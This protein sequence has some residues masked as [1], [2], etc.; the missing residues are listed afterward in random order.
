MTD[1]RAALPPLPLFLGLL[2]TGPTT[3]L[4]TPALF[5]R[6]LDTGQ[7]LFELICGELRASATPLT[8]EEQQV[9]QLPA[10]QPLVQR[11]KEAAQL[12]RYARY[13][14]GWTAPYQIIDCPLDQAA[15]AAHLVLY[16]YQDDGQGYVIFGQTPEAAWARFLQ[17]VSSVFDGVA[18][19][20]RHYWALLEQGRLEEAA[21]MLPTFGI[22]HVERRSVPRNPQISR[23][24]QQ[25]E[26]LLKQR[27]A[28]HLT[29]DTM[30][31]EEMVTDLLQTLIDHSPANAWDLN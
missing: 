11:L 28:R 21:Q 31:A 27:L 1:P 8:W 7:A 26:V 24:R 20:E 5:H 25:V 23:A 14:T 10:S 3:Q 9:L 17:E 4:L 12:S 18:P 29:L 15:D 16:R 13:S 6:S 30:K 19:A 2:T 22:V